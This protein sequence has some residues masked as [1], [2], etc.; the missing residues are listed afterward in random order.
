MT[1][2]H[3]NIVARLPQRRVLVVCAVAISFVFLSCFG[4]SLV[5]MIQYRS[6]GRFT[7]SIQNGAIV[8][9]DDP[10]SR[11]S[12]APIASTIQAEGWSTCPAI[13]ADYRLIELISEIRWLPSVRHETKMA[14]GLPR[15][16]IIVT[17]FWIP[18]VCLLLLA[19]GMKMQCRIHRGKE[20][21]RMCGYSLRGLKENSPCPECNGSRS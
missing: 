10:I 18:I 8:Y 3:S 12:L 14:P 16:L 15:F 21:C 20:Q 13:S 11:G 4:L 6:P 2:A 17:P 9:T 5:R 7:A 1:T 19:I